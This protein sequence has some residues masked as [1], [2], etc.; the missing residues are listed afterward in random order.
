MS[1]PPPPPPP[2]PPSFLPSFFAPAKSRYLSWFGSTD[3]RASDSRA[4]SGVALNEFVRL[5][6]RGA[7]VEKKTKR[8]TATPPA[9]LIM[10]VA[11]TTVNYS[12]LASAG[13]ISPLHHESKP[14]HIFCFFFSL[15]P[16]TIFSLGW[17]ISAS[18]T[19]SANLITITT[20]ARIEAS[21]P[22]NVLRGALR[23]GSTLF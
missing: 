20:E 8:T 18:H 17:I 14:Q 3:E 4:E 5:L 16:F 11:A 9:T 10:P 6:G 23:F 1:P 7:E 22:G 2:P 15:S 19:L 12:L 13:P 21:A